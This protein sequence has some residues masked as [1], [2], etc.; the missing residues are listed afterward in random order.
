M[1]KPLEKVAAFLL[2]IGL[3][4]GRSIIAL[5]DNNEI[6][7]LVPEI[8][9]IIDLSSEIQESVRND[10]E[11]LGYKDNMR[12]S[13]VLNVIRFMF[14]GSNIHDSEKRKFSNWR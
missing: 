10:F 5:M 4:R 6:K 11:Q 9:K 8:E 7:A 1:L 14:N 2:L 12:P 13:E 3:E